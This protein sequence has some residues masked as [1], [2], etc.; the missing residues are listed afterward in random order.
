MTWRTDEQ[1]G[2]SGRGETM[3]VLRSFLAGIDALYLTIDLD[4]LPASVAPGVSAPAAL[5]VELSA[6]EEIVE[7]AKASGKLRLADVAELNPEFD[8]DGRTARVAAR[9]VWRL[10][11]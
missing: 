6:V 11:R 2:R 4:V 3:E 1:V 8:V 10:A 5:G 7:A 9:L